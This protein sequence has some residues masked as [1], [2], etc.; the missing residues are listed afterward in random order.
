MD[1]SRLQ[2]AVMDVCVSAR[3]YCKLCVV[4]A[5]AAVMSPIQSV[6]SQLHLSLAQLSAAAAAE[7]SAAVV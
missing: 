4:C 3:V 7:M 5:A 1:R 2:L 6:S